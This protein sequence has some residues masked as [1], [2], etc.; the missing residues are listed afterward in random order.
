MVLESVV[1][2]V[3]PSAMVLALYL[4][5]SGHNQPGGGFVGGLVAGSAFP[6]RYAPRGLCAGTR[7]ARGPPRV[8]V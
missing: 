6:P 5:F 3:F 2:V 1:R 4:L 7:A 8:P